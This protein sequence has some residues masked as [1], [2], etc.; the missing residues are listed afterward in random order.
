MAGVEDTATLLD[1]MREWGA[2]RMYA[3]LRRAC[4][5]PDT[6]S[7]AYPASDRRDLE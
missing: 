1:Q 2:E 5:A 4:A 7:D 3:G 6:M